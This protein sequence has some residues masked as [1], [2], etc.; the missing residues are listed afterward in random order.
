MVYKS[1]FIEGAYSVEGNEHGLICSIL[2]FRDSEG[3]VENILKVGEE[4]NAETHRQ[5][6]QRVRDLGTLTL[7]GDVSI[8]SP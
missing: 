3:N 2:H 1:C 5:C 7:K 4:I 6:V 8:N